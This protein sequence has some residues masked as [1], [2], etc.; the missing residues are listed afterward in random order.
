MDSI[1]RIW[2]VGAFVC[3]RWFA[4]SLAS[5]TGMI[6]VESSARLWLFLRSGQ[7]WVSWFGVAQLCQLF[8]R[9]VVL[10]LFHFG[11]PHRDGIHVRGFRLRS[12]LSQ[13]PFFPVSAGGSNNSAPCRHRLSVRPFLVA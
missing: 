8:Q 13:R 4:R 3:A 5:V 12:C 1:Q 10:F 11:Q 9:L 6:L 2:L 7:V